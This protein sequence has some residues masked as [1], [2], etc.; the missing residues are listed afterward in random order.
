MPPKPLIDLS[1]IDLDTV[2]FDA[3]ALDRYLPQKHAMR[4]LHGVLHLDTEE[5]YAVGYRDV[6]D[7]EFW[8][9]GHFPSRPVFPGVVLVESVAQLCV[10]YWR[11]Q[12]GIEQAP[13]RAMLFGGIDRVKFRDAIVPGQRVILVAKATEVKVR[14]SRYDCQAFVEGK[15]VFTGEITGMLGPSMPEIYPDGV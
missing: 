13:G 11:H 7:D 5:G 12:V 9:E 1:S 3:T 14:R 15:L 6:R 4:Q 10:F 8:C 2:R